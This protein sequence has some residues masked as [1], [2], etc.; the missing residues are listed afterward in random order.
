MSDF[1]CGS[2]AEIE[3]I[4]RSAFRAETF[5]I[6]DDPVDAGIHT[7]KIRVSE[8]LSEVTDPYIE[9]SVR[10]DYRTAARVGEFHI[11]INIR[12]PIGVNSS[13]IREPELKLR[14][15]CKRAPN[16]RCAGQIRVLCPEIQIQDVDLA[17]NLCVRYVLFVG[18]E[19]DMYDNG[20]GKNTTPGYRVSSSSGSGFSFEPEAGIAKVGIQFQLARI[21]GHRTALA[22][23]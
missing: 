14:I 18:V 17:L 3:R 10:I 7:G 23:S 9:V 21:G 11:I 22:S 4:S 16:S 20:D 1:V 6:D 13:H 8:D 2:T 12:R 15:C 5:K 19:N